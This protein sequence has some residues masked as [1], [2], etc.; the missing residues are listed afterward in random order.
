MENQSIQQENLNLINKTR[1]N[2]N[3]KKKNFTWITVLWIFAVIAIAVIILFVVF[4]ALKP[5][6]VDPY[7]QTINVTLTSEDTYKNSEEIKKIKFP[8]DVVDYNLKISN[9]LQN[10]YDIYLRFKALTYLEG[11]NKPN[12]MEIY[13]TNNR[14]N[15]YYDEQTDTWYYI[16]KILIGEELNICDKIGVSGGKTQNEYANKSISFYV[17]V[18]AIKAT[19]DNIWNDEGGVRWREIMTEKGLF[20]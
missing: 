8:S 13:I 18:E 19:N 6:P 3:K 11:E 10:E 4:N 17:L 14:E 16:G 12:I 7:S 5:I 20:E 2:S 15:F 9:D 1:K